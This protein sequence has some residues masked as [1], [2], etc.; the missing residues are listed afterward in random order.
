M[1][2]PPRSR[3]VEADPALTALVLITYAATNS[4]ADDT[5]I[6]N[7]SPTVHTFLNT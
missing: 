1:P 3:R 7:T 6:T 5:H 2:A 4:I